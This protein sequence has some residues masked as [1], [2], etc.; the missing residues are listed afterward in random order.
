[1]N[2]LAVSARRDGTRKGGY[3]AKKESAALTM[4]LLAS[5][6]ELQHA[7]A[8]AADLGAG[9]RVVSLPCFEFVRPPERRVPRK[10]VAASLP[11]KRIAIE[12]GVTGPCGGNM[13][14]PRVRCSASTASAS[15]LPATP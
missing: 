8:A 6:S 10:R 1:M 2:G 12:A 11:P 15:A 3:I 13:S 9:V 5:G 7:M 4:I 14:V